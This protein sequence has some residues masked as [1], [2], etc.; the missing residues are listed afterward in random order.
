[1]PAPP[2][3]PPR[4]PSTATAP[5]I[6]SAGSITS[7]GTLLSQAA[8]GSTRGSV[9]GSG[10]S[11]GGGGSSSKGWG[12]ANTSL[13]HGHASMEAELVDDSAPDADAV[14]WLSASA[15]GDGGSGAVECV[16]IPSS[17][18]LRRGGG[19]GSSGGAAARSLCDDI[20]EVYD[21]VDDVALISCV[22]DSAADL[23][24]EVSDTEL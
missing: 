18:P 7:V 3:L 16:V 8:G 23:T 15:D 22:P 11:G 14:L 6:R 13:V 20:V 19:G 10:G 12:D 5:S 4:P 1:L 2:L 17:P 21:S 9:H 24:E